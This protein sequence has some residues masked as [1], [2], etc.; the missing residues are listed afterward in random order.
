[1][2]EHHPE[3]I[4]LGFHPD[5]PF[6][7]RSRAVQAIQGHLLDMLDE[8]SHIVGLQKGMTVEKALSILA[9]L[10][11]VRYAEPD[12]IG[13]GGAVSN[14]PSVV[15]GQ[16][17]GLY[18]DPVNPF[19][20]QATLAWAAD[21]IG[22]AKV[23]VG[24][25]DTGVNYAHIDLYQNIAIRQDLIPAA[26]K[27]LL[28]DADHDG[29][30]TFRDLNDPANA[31]HVKDY[32][33]DGRI[34]F[35]DLLKDP[36][37]AVPSGLCGWDFVNSDNDPLDDLGHGTHC[38]GTI[39]AVGGNGAGVAGVNWNCQIMPLKVI[40]SS[41]YVYWSTV[42]KALDYFIAAAKA[43]PG[44]RYA[45]T[46]NSYGGNGASTAMNDAIGRAAKAGILFVAAAGNYA[47]NTD[48]SS[49][50]PSC[51]STLAAAG[52]EAVVSVAAIGSTGGLASWSNYG[53]KT[54]DIAAPGVGIY[55]TVKGGGYG[56]MSGTSM[57]T[58]H[59]AGALALFCAA[60]PTMSGAAVRDKML[61]TAPPTQ[62]VLGKVA[63]NGRISLSRMLDIAAPLPAPS[64][65]STTGADTLAG[66][67]AADTLAGGLGDDRYTVDNPGDKVVEQSGEGL[68]KIYATVDTILPPNVERLYFSGTA[69]NTGLGNLLNNVVS[70][71]AGANRLGGG[72][73]NDVVSGGGGADTLDGGSGN[74][75]L[76][77]G[78]GI[79]KFEITR[80]EGN[81]TIKDFE[82]GEKIELHLFSPGSTVARVAGS[83]TDWI[84]TDAATGQTNVFRLVNSYALTPSDFVFV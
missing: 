56:S 76:T 12:Y 23:V 67:S 52:W 50:Y 21:K 3:R 68:D 53:P 51:C 25:L 8:H 80:G 16:T 69:P 42:V 43:N 29:V 77:G 75:T 13:H 83:L 9:H 30:I 66:T 28:V 62:S 2:L 65:G 55:S 24:V 36:R 61:K 32:D 17:W 70:G 49:F 47:T 64:E 19:G 73:G 81:D 58:P 1:M 78:T 7:H 46:S 14:D 44:Q 74:D 27:P 59:V 4:L 31:A 37:W 22:S 79:D 11:G 18:S 39:G 5:A 6:D 15:N 34:T 45:A 26:L 33:G 54:V 41:N 10:P 35:A 48:N 57:A 84:V 20:V 60:N 72:A 63:C 38:A 40:S 71:N 82:A